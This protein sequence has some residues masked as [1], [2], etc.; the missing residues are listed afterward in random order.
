MLPLHKP[1]CK[2]SAEDGQTWR[3]SAYHAGMPLIK[4]QG[5]HDPQGPEERPGRPTST[6]L[7]TPESDRQLQKK[8][9]PKAFQHVSLN[10]WVD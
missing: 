1:F 4:V 3:S 5:L 6:A 10:F 8:K 2:N 7:L 9:L